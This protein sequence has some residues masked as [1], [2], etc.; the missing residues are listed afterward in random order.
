MTWGEKR[1]LGGGK[2]KRNQPKKKWV[3]TKGEKGEMVK[4]ATPNKGRH[5]SKE[6]ASVKGVQEKGDEKRKKNNLKKGKKT[7]RPQGHLSTEGNIN[8]R[9][10]RNGKRKVGRHGKC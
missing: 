7:A 10:G 8:Q 6:K 9:G 5:G 1:K 3:K 2:K 4:R